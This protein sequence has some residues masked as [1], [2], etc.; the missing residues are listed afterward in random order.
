[1]NDFNYT[2]RISRKLL[3]QYA[4]SLFGSLGLVS[5]L[6]AA[7]TFFFA[8]FPFWRSNVVLT[9]L[10]YFCRDYILLLFL[11]SV[12]LC[13][14]GC[15]VHFIRK[16]LDF[17]DEMAEA[18]EQLTQPD[19]DPI[20]LSPELGMLEE[21]LNWAHSQALRDQR[22]A[23]EAE[24]RKN[25]LVVYLAHD[26]KTPLTSVIG[27]LTLLRDEPDLSPELRGRYTG[28]AL[29]KA[30][31]LE[32]LINEFF[33][34]TRFNLARMELEKRPCDLSRM[35]QQ[36]AS[37]FAPMLAERQLSCE[38]NLPESMPYSCDPD[39]LARVFDNLLRNACWYSK[40]GTAVGIAATRGEGVLTLTF[41][42]SGVTI[43]PEKLGRIFEQ[44]FRLDSSRATRTGG[45]GLGLAIA[46]EIVELHG[47]SISARSEDGETVFTVVLPAGCA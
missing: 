35:L 7:C 18:A 31:R 12:G 2:G 44:F 19:D 16:P 20:V 17:L 45:A 4:L 5:F 33:E 21:H 9:Y 41:T 10:L 36:V 6:A 25:D 47:G 43:P 14:L 34:I 40:A 28:V 27:Y 15:T 29:D 1:M 30:E 32:D 3:G 23:R 24:Q 39:K 37:E 26:L 46:K 38:L 22:A 11:I 42:N 13:W 8:S